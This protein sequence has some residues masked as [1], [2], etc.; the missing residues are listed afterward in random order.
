MGRLHNLERDVSSITAPIAYS[1]SVLVAATASATNYCKTTSPK[2]SLSAMLT[3]KE[4]KLGVVYRRRLRVR[5]AAGYSVSL[6]VSSL[7]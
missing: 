5:P 4:T 2:W 6:G 7:D 1:F 3:E